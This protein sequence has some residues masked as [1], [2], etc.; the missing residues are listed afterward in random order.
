MIRYHS[1][2]L[3]NAEKYMDQRTREYERKY[4]SIFRKV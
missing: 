2:E 3:G 1:M 4:L